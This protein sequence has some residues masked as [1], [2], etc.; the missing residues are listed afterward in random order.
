MDPATVDRFH[1]ELRERLVVAAHVGLH[2]GDVMGLI[3][4]L[5]HHSIQPDV[6]PSHSVVRI[7]LPIGGDIAVGHQVVDGGGSGVD[8]L[9]LEV[10]VDR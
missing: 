6:V 3:V 9:R 8:S 10:V 4:S 1:Q 7:G 5:C 2:L